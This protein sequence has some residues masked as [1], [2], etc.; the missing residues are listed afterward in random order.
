MFQELSSWILSLVLWTQFVPVLLVNSSDQITSF[1][2]NLE[3]V[4]TGLRVTI[5]RVLS[6]LTLSSTSLEKKLKVLIAFKAFR[7]PTHLV[8]ELVQEWVLS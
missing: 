2:V 7:S 1:L 5:L 4:I 3:Q 8:E 6:S